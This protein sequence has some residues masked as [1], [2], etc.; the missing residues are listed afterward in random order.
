MVTDLY[1]GTL[2]VTVI[3]VYVTYRVLEFVMRELG[4]CAGT[5][6]LIVAAIILCRFAVG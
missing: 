6:L 1:C 5:V 3:G 4:G 2:I